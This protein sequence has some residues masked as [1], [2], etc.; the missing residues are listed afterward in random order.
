MCEPKVTLYIRVAMKKTRLHYFDMLK[1]IAIFMVIMG[2]VLTMCIR[3]IDSAVLFKFV[4]K[5]HMPIFFFISGYFTYKVLEN[6]KLAMPKLGVRVKQLLV[7]F[8]VVSALWIYYFPHSGL[9][10]PFVSTWEGL[11]TSVGKNGYWFTLSLFEIIL[12]YC[13]LVPILSLCRRML[14]KVGVIALSWLLLLGL[15]KFWLPAEVNNVLSL[16]L[17]AE[18]FPVFMFG[19]VA[20]GSR[21][22]FDK[23]ISSSSWITVAMIVGSVVMYY[24]CWPWEFSV[25]VACVDFAKVILYI[26]VVMVAVAVVKPWSEQSFSKE[27]PEGGRFAR[28]W[29][30]IGTQSLAIYMLHY[31]FLFPMSAL[32]EPLIGMNL[33]L[34]PTLIV[35]AFFASVIIAVVLGV[36]YIIS[37]SNLLA[38]LLTGKVK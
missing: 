10:S 6:G 26:C 2:H 8:F 12:I 22:T 37:R 16:S 23:V 36:N 4:E 15:S 31:F 24:V 17:T 27:R 5:I 35:A 21:D 38:L 29:E 30:Y 11:Y 28:M 19:A 13:A 9:Q 7:P 18:F 3:D 20:R 34:I 14:S 33:N 25:P 32:R 1:G